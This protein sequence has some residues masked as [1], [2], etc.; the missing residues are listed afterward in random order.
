MGQSLK[1]KEHNADVR[2]LTFARACLSQAAG[3]LEGSDNL[4]YRLP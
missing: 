1:Q 2:R 3:G 4:F